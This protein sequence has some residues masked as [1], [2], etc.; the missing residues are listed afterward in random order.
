MRHVV[1]A[2]AL[3]IAACGGEA[4]TT[5]DEP[6]ATTGA[7]AATETPA[8]TEAPEA[9]PTTTIAVA[10]E[11]CGGDATGIEIGSPVEDQVDMDGDFTEHV[12]FCV[13]VPGG[14]STLTVT[15][16]GLEANL[17]VYVGYP[18]LETVKSGGFTF[19][20]SDNDDVADENLVINRGGDRLLDPGPYYIEVSSPDGRGVSPFRLLVETS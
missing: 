9:G 15:L 20:F 10:T 6:V 12:Y 7:P 4:V 2:V 18:D 3:L 16:T 17:D 8:T 14:V 11:Q 19:W 5:T 13:D 1:A